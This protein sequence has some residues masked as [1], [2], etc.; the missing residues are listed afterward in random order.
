MLPIYIFL[1]ICSWLTNQFQFPDEKLCTK[2]IHTLLKLDDSICE[3]SQKIS[4]VKHAW[5]SGYQSDLLT[6]DMFAFGI[7]ML[8]LEGEKSNDDMWKV[9]TQNI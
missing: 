9:M 6:N 8:K 2:Y 7:E 5:W 3:D 1:N 4:A